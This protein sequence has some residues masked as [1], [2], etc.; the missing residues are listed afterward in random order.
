MNITNGLENKMLQRKNS[1]FLFVMCG[2]IIF[3]F[4][5]I[6]LMELLKYNSIIY[7]TDF[8]E[9]PMG[10]CV[11]I[12]GVFRL[13]KKNELWIKKC[14]VFICVAM[15]AIYTFYIVTI[16]S[17]YD[18][19]FILWCMTEYYFKHGSTFAEG[20]VK[21]FTFTFVYIV[22]ILLTRIITCLWILNNLV[23]SI[24]KIY[25]KNQYKERLVICLISLM[26]TII[27]CL[28]G[29]IL[30]KNVMNGSISMVITTINPLIMS[31]LLVIISYISVTQM[32]NGLLVQIDSDNENILKRPSDEADIKYTDRTEEK[33]NNI[34]MVRK[35]QKMK[36]CSHCGKEIFD[37][38]V[39]CP[40]CGCAVAGNDLKRITRKD[41]PS[42]G[43]NILSFF[44]PIVGLILYLLL[45][46]EEPKK[47]NAV[48]KW[49]LIGVGVGLGLWIIITIISAMMNAIVYI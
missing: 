25:V 5:W 47:A 42:T 45:K 11:L 15:L 48:G 16:F 21:E 40:N 35:E 49:A 18:V 46:D 29:S 10:I 32:K 30:Y 2:G 13:R 17:D 36:Y 27:L 7:M 8:I 37:E 1:G 19:S 14:S 22:M 12:M 33:A 44:I 26:I 4:G 38:A 20:W 24:K 6:K 3:L 43:L 9:L 39:I 41:T 34:K 28:T 23:T 31:T